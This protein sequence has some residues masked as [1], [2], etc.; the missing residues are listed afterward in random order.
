[1][2]DTPSAHYLA[3]RQS[4]VS[5]FAGV[6]AVYELLHESGV[7]QARD[8]PDSWGI[9]NID[10]RW[11]PVAETAVV[12]AL[13]TAIAFLEDIADVDPDS[14]MPSNAIEGIAYDLGQMKPD[15]RQRFLD[16][17]EALAAEKAQNEEFDRAAWIRN[18]PIALR[19][20]ERS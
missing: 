1:L 17:V 16:A 2:T 15:E 3:Q 6:R 7:N 10:V 18:V 4:V 19:L 8:L 11:A 5:H 20:V 13:L 12:R 9:S 14:S